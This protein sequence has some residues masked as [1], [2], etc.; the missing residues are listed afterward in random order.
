MRG[1]VT[2]FRLIDVISGTTSQTVDLPVDS[3]TPDTA[4]RWDP[5]DQQ[6]IYNMSTSSLAA[7]KTYLFRISLNDGSNIDFRFALK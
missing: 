6:W 7:G 3:T 4:F 1:V 2:S 5:T